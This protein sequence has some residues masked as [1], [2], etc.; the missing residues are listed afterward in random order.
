MAPQSRADHRWVALR[1]PR[2]VFILAGAACM[3][4]FLLLI[5][6]PRQDN[7]L[8]S[9]D[10]AY[11]YAYLRSAIMDGDLDIANDLDIYNAR[12][13]P[14]N[15]GRA[16]MHMA[17]AFAIGTPILWAP[18]WIPAHLI[19]GAL[20]SAGLPVSPDGH[21]RIE[22]SAA[23]L[24][25]IAWLVF[26]LFL[27]FRT[28]EHVVSPRTALL[29]VLLPAAGSPIISQALLETWMSHAGE[30]FTV[31]LFLWFLLTRFKPTPTHWALTG[32][33]L[34]AV[35]LVRWQNVVFLPFL[36]TAVRAEWN[37]HTHRIAAWCIVR[38]LLLAASAFTLA[39]LPQALF[40]HATLGGWLLVPQGAGFMDD[41]GR[42]VLQVLASPRHGLFLWA[43]VL[44]L[45]A[46]GVVRLRHRLLRIITLM[47]MAGA[48]L[49]CGST[50]QWWAG[51]SF[52]M[53]R[54]VGIVPLFMLGHAELLDAAAPR[55][56]RWLTIASLAAVGWTLVLFAAYAVKWIPRDAS[57][58]P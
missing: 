25:N 51:E 58:L 52:G 1:E 45:A 50:W 11:Y 44:A 12:M 24:A 55:A 15:P 23:C 17:Y 36:L 6:V 35:F 3:L 29:S 38:G 54:L 41:A 7:H 39:A 22:E 10:G 37:T 53:R 47:V 19:A 46:I 32:L 21:S 5:P 16:G 30:V 49:V 18:A 43:P 4:V 26:G 33:L 8:I 27:V 57:F 9:G 2:T 13:E 28:I 14:G 40:W 56:R 42:H 48:I 20:G 31:G 34:G